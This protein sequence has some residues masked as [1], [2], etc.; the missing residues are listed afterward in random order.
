MFLFLFFDPF[1][2]AQLS[3]LLGHKYNNTTSQSNTHNSNS[4]LITEFYMTTF[5]TL[6]LLSIHACLFFVQWRVYNICL[7][8]MMEMDPTD[9]VKLILKQQA[10]YFKLPNILYNMYSMCRFWGRMWIQADSVKSYTMCDPLSFSK[11]TMPTTGYCRLKSS[12]F[13]V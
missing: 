2:K 7:L 5:V 8:N 13:K 6:A 4:Q 11:V 9:K 3:N 10:T 12:S 1:S